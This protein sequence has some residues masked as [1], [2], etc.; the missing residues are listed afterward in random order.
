[1]AATYTDKRFSSKRMQRLDRIEQDF[2]S[3][4]L[5][6]LPVSPSILDAPCGSGR[7]HGVFAPAAGH[8]TMLDFSPDMLAQVRQRY[9]ADSKLE[10]RQGDVTTLPFPDATFDLCFC[11]RLFHH[12]LDD[13]T[14][15]KALSELARVSRRYVAM[16]FYDSRSFRYLR[17]VMLGKRPS[18]VSI[19]MPHMLQLARQAGLGLVRKVPSISFIEQQRMLLLEKVGSSEPHRA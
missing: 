13:P 15:L 16:S 19:P 14:R 17:R 5:P 12:M 18:G 4:L 7:F 2:A 6:L 1:M 3:S 9:T 10:L 8:S 11:M